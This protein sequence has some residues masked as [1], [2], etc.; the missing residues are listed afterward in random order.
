[1]KDSLFALPATAMLLLLCDC[2]LYTE[3]LGKGGISSEGLW[4]F[5]VLVEEWNEALVNRDYLALEEL[6][7]E[8]VF[9]YGDLRTNQEVVSHKRKSLESNQLWA[10]QIQGP[11]Q[12]SRIP[13]I[14]Q[15]LV[16]TEFLK[17]S[18]VAS[19]MDT[20]LAYLVFEKT[21]ST[22][23][24]VQE[25]DFSTDLVLLKRRV[26]N[27]Q[28]ENETT[29]Q[30]EERIKEAE[31]DLDWYGNVRFGWS[32]FYPSFFEPQ[33]ESTNGDGQKFR[34][35]DLEIVTHFDW[36]TRCDA[37][38]RHCAEYL[39][40]VQFQSDTLANGTIVCTKKV[41]T[42][43]NG[44]VLEVKYPL[45]KSLLIQEYIDLLRADLNWGLSMHYDDSIISV[46]NN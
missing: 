17:V 22:W 8:D 27:Q 2:S 37:E 38:N 44:M 18:G 33:G 9:V 11:I 6:Y 41:S 28:A 26:R 10:Q 40:R 31:I 45:S 24:I 35:E 23:R 25:S 20:V 43:S 4:S 3:D 16:R 15:G 19:D 7:A 36:D 34:Y 14:K 46:S 12:T 21:E 42:S 1:M 32:L 29:V 13:Q 30:V 39:N 5:S